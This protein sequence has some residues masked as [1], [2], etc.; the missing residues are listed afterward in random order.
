MGRQREAES[1]RINHWRIA[2][3]EKSVA[4]NE[5]VHSSDLHDWLK[6]DLIASFLQSAHEPFLRVLP[7]AFIK[8]VAPQIFIALLLAQD[9]VDDH[10]NG[11]SNRN[12]CSLPSAGHLAH[13]FE[14]LVVF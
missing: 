13:P 7:I 9:M 10:Q 6:L 12:E 1:H 11:V 14:K 4:N 8:R 5:R 3:S 2:S